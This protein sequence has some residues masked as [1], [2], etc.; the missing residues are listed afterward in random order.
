MV[1]QVGYSTRVKAF[2]PGLKD[3]YASI[4]PGRPIKKWKLETAWDYLIR[5]LC[6]LGRGSML[7]GV[8]N[9]DQLL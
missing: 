4:I 5:R 8:K 6:C 1:W 3:V 9:P 7:L 2:N